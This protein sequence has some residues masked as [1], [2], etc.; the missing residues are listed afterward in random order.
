M[1][2][3]DPIFP[4][5]LD[6]NMA[7]VTKGEVHEALEL[8]EAAHADIGTAP[9]EVA[10]GNH[11]HPDLATSANLAA[12]TLARI[13]GDDALQT[14]K[15]P[16]AHTHPQSDITNLTTAL[17]G[18]SD[19]G[20]THTGLSVQAAGTPSVRALGTGATDA[21]AGNDSRLSDARTPTA[22]THP[23]S[24]V[25]NLATTL[26]GKSDT[27]HTHTGLSVQAAATPSVRALGTGATDAAAGNDS[28]LS[29]ARTPVAHTHAQADVTGLTASLAGKSDTSHTHAAATTSVAGFLS[30][31]DKLKLDSLKV[32]YTTRAQTD[33]NGNYT[34]TYP[35][36]FAT[37]PRILVVAE[38]TSGTTDVINAQVN[39][40]P[41]TTQCV[42]K[43]NRT[44]QSVAALLGLTILSV[45]GTVGATWVH[46]A[47]YTP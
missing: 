4:S 1:D 8:K 3:T 21:A 7:A 23:Q 2:P 20:H 31:V 32:V 41:T 39:G 38:T 9:D 6:A 28:R 34:W 45:P 44:Q 35:A 18:K 36:A 27:S 47:A 25:V 13:A 19:T 17:A 46:I 42:I 24:D 30:A 40:T 29:D 5:A 43:V 26:A 11:T 12:E 14:S 15:A 10:A 22:H 33:A 37:A 16:V